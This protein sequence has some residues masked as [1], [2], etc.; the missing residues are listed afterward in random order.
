MHSPPCHI[1]GSCNVKEGAFGTT[2]V[3]VDSEL[4]SIFNLLFVTLLPLLF[5]VQAPPVIVFSSA[6]AGLAGLSFLCIV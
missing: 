2:T 6:C 4:F 1:H 5:L 3:A